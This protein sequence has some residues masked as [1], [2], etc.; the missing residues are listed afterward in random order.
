MHAIPEHAMD[1][2]PPR[3]DRV[4]GHAAQHPRQRGDRRQLRE[5]SQRRDLERCDFAAPPAVR[6][7]WY[8]QQQEQRRPEADG[9]E[10]PGADDRVEA[11]H[12]ETQQSGVAGMQEPRRRQGRRGSKNL[13]PD[14]SAA[15]RLVSEFLRLLSSLS[16]TLSAM[17]SL[18]ES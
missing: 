2:E 11:L 18:D 17:W 7:A 4:R 9:G 3:S 16:L 5:R 12:G 1:D 14:Y 6:P 13:H 10:M 8:E 15:P